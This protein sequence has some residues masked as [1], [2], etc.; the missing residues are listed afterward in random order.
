[1]GTQLSQTCDLT[2]MADQYIMIKCTAITGKV[3]GATA[4]DN[5]SA[6][7]YQGGSDDE[8]PPE[9]WGGAGRWREVKGIRGTGDEEEER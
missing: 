3:L 6:S 9:R 2:D 7:P 5:R 1:M 8:S 4:T